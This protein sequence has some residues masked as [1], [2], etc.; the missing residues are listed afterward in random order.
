[1]SSVLK[2]AQ[3]FF[4]YLKKHNFHNLFKLTPLL[5]LK[6]SQTKSFTSIR[7]VLLTVFHLRH[8]LPMASSCILF[9]VSQTQ[10]RRILKETMDYI[11]EK[12]Q[13]II[14]PSKQSESS[15]YFSHCRFIVDATELQINSSVYKTYSGK[16]K[17]FAIKYQLLVG[18]E[19]GKICHVFGPCWGS[20]HDITIY[21]KSGVAEWL[22][23]N[24]EYC[25]GDCGYQG[26]NRVIVPNKK[27]HELSPDELEYNRRIH[28]ERHTVERTFGNLKKW[29]ILQQVYRGKI[30]EH[31]PV[32]LC[33]CILTELINEF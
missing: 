20:H 29:K 21:K 2:V 14:S 33:C 32:F 15:N 17:M 11:I 3:T 5:V 1:M 19:T 28:S 22:A 13:H 23:E 7:N 24:N 27:S 12:F 10:F 31:F 26:G 9:N 16:S 25:M 6:L 30:S 18:V 8:Y 4:P